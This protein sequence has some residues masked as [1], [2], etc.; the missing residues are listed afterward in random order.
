MHSSLF[1][2]MSLCL[3]TNYKPPIEVFLGQDSSHFPKI[4]G[5]AK[6]NSSIV[7]FVGVASI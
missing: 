3:K 7:S 2:S 6:S 5:G 1:N 4:L